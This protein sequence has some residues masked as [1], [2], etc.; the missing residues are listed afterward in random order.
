MNTNELIEELAKGL[1]PAP[2][3]WRPGRRTLV[4]AL[5]AAAYVAVLAALVAR[6][7]IANPAAG[8]GFWWPQIAAF[9]AAVVAARAAF[10]SVVPGARGAGGWAALAALAWLVS[11]G[12]TASWRGGAAILASG[13]EWACVAFIALGGLP[14]LAASAFALRRGAA[15]RPVATGALAALAVG[16]LASVGACWSLPHP[17]N[18]VTLVWHGAAVLALTLLGAAAAVLILRWPRGARRD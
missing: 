4:W 6:G 9:V 3:L 14:L 5:A 18:D 17:A 13:H 16:A 2:P 1:A 7:T 12:A 15:L 8:A 11:L 10:A